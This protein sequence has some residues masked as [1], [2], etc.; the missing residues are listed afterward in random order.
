MAYAFEDKEREDELAQQGQPKQIGTESAVIQEGAQPTEQTDKGSGQYVNLE[1]YLKSN[2]PRQFGQEVAGKIGEKITGAEQ[3]QKQAETGFKGEVDKGAVDYNE[4]LVK[5]AA[6]RPE[7]VAGDEDLYNQFQ[8]Q[9][10]AQY[11]GP[12]NLVDRSDIFSPAQRATREA[13]E[14]A[15]LTGDE[16]GRQTI[17][18]RYYGS[19]AGNSGYTRGQQNLDNLLISND[20][21]ARDAFE[22]QRQRAQGVGQGYQSLQDQLNQYAQQKALSTKT[23]AEKAQELVGGSKQQTQEQINKRYQDT[24]SGLNAQTQKA[25]ELAAQNKISKDLAD[26]YG[27]QSMR[28]FGVN[29]SDYIR[30][31]ANPTIHEVVTPEERN[32]YEA[33]AKLMGGEEDMLPYADL[34]GKFDQSKYMEFDKDRYLNDVKAKEAQYNQFMTNPWWSWGNTINGGGVSF[35]GGQRL[36]NNDPIF[37]AIRGYT[38]PRN[39]IQDTLDFYKTDA[40]QAFLGPPGDSSSTS[41]YNTSLYNE[42][43]RLVGAVKDKYG[44][45]KYLNIEDTNY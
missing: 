12:N 15:D 38:L 11:K 22:A 35:S 19:G 20:P 24:V 34:A 39:S 32:R 31:A 2:A 16:Y 40:G 4:E 7:E 45:D 18:D 6:E 17:L 5:R 27:I 23:A 1:N 14:E 13:T 3:A 21:N 29:P 26:R 43:Q 9:R 25:K 28:N 30:T 44:Y 10:T 37:D 36:N 33:L 41:R 42:L 8:S